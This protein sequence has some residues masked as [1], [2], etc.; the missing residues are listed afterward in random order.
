MY[1]IGIL[2]GL[3]GYTIFVLGLLFAFSEITLL[4]VTSIFIVAFILLF[5]LR[6]LLTT[7]VYL[8]LGKSSPIIIVYFIILFFQLGLNLIIGA[9]SPE[10]AFDAL[11]Y[12]LTLPKLYLEAGGLSYFS[13]GLLYYSAM[14]QLGEMYY[15]AALFWG[16]EI[17]AKIIHYAFGLLG[18]YVLYRV[19]RM[20]ISTHMSIAIILL[21]YSNLVVSWESTT[22]YIDLIRTYWELLAMFAYLM[23]YKTNTKKHLLFLGIFLGFAIST[24]LLSLGSLCIFV[25]LL[26]IQKKELLYTQLL[27]ATIV[28]VTTLCIVSPW[29]IR[30]YYYTGNPFYPFFSNI[31]P[32]SLGIH[33]IS[34]IMFIRD[35]ITIF[36]F[37]ADPISPLYIVSLPLILIYYKKFTSLQKIIVVYCLLAYLLWYITPRT[38]GGRFI[39]PYIGIFSLLV[40][41]TLE[42]TNKNIRSFTIGLIIIVAVITIGYR[43]AAM[44]KN[45]PY[46]LGTVSKEQFLRS[47]LN[48]SFGDFYDIDN[49]FSRTIDSND[50]VLL[51]GIHNLYYVNFPFIHESYRGKHDTFNYILTQNAALPDEFRSFRKVYENP[52]THVI[53]YK[54]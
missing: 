26:L 48:Y 20:Y 54:K 12:H 23:F 9:L 5:I 28:I 38:G 45:I 27:N 15:V 16:N 6:I 8:R 18:L 19:S 51:I 33:A 24:K 11:W 10:L 52:K 42:Y 34:P 50:K 35:F 7:R 32:V 22:A 37:S 25:L 31:Y 49:Y 44:S 13:G 46:I 21:Y 36:L 29:L 3:Y 39:M 47:N 53:L 40:G 41:I 30:A 2:I 4:W 43:A 17:T 14:P 1:K